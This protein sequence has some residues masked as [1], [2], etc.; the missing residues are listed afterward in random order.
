MYH[1]QAAAQYRQSL[2]D[3]DDGRYA[4]V[5][6]L[7]LETRLTSHTNRYGI[8]LSRL[9]IALTAAK[10]ASAAARKG[11]VVRSVQNDTKV[12]TCDLC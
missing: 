8:Q 9:S 6:F 4:Q 11:N 2:N 12:Q 3:S 10:N 5:V 1:F 7:S